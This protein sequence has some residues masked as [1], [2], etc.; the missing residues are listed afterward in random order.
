MKITIIGPYPPFRGGISDFN[1]SL[2][3]E[4]SKKNELQLINFSVQYPKLLFPGK[5]QYKD[6]IKENGKSIRILNSVNYLSWIK[7]VKN[8]KKFSP[9]LVLFQYWMPFFA[10][11]YNS[12]IKKLNNRNFHTLAIC[13][14][15]I[16]HEDKSFYNYLTKRFVNRIDKFIVMS[17]SVRADLM[18]LKP[19][20]D[21]VELF[22]PIYDL[23][24]EEIQKD[25]AKQKLGITEKNV[26]LFFGLIREY[27]G[28]DILLKA[29]SLLSKHLKDFKLIIAGECY[30]NPQKY[31]DIIN[32]LDIEHSLEIRME[33]I[34]DSDVKCYFSAADVVVLPYKTATQSGITQI[35][36]NFNRPVILSDVGGLSEIIIDGKTGYVVNPNSNDVTNAISKFFADNKFQEFHDNIIEYKK[37]FS[38]ETFAERLIEFTTE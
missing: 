33:F 38:W 37:N 25:T 17:K 36:Y 12:I 11:A 35:A 24:G 15:L 23:F 4:L 28:L 1:Y 2:V 22:H 16:P 27:K 20:A 14:N 21:N 34:S 6:E 18:E 7:T 32:R 31:Y 3:N 30:E 5:T 9:D 29:V 19:N 10:F 26:A 8:I 13:H